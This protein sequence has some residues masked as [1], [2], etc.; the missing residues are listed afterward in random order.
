MKKQSHL[1]YCIYLRTQ[2]GHENQVTILQKNAI[3][4]IK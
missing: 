4:E 2:K 1:K 3:I